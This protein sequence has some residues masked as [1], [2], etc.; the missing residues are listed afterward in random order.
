MEQNVHEHVV[1][2]NEE[3]WQSFARQRSAKGDQKI[4]NKT[5]AN[6]SKD[7]NKCFDLLPRTFE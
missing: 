6:P 3:I 2:T 1:R 5:A 4:A 7:P